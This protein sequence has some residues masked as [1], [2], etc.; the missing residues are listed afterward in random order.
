MSDD[1]TL[2]LEKVVRESG[3]SGCGFSDLSDLQNLPYPGLNRSVTVL[4]ALDPAIIEI[5][6]A[7]CRERV[8]LCV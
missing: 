5:G 3:G 7:S 2:E 8:Y 4:L 6:R 1:L